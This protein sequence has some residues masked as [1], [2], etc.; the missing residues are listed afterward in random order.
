M[1]FSFLVR[2]NEVERVS[3]TLKI[4]TDMNARIEMISKGILTSVGTD[5]VQLDVALYEIM[6]DSS[7]VRDLT[8][9]KAKPTPISIFVNSS[10]RSC[11][12]SLGIEMQIEE[13]KGIMIGSSG[14]LSREKFEEASKEYKILKEIM[15]DY[16]KSQNLTPEQYL[17][18]KKHITTQ[19]S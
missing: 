7:A 11:A 15:V 19:S 17:K 10:F 5:V 4:M 12:K 13:D 18:Q 1:M 6:L 3:D 8:Y 16:L 9:W 2:K 14:G